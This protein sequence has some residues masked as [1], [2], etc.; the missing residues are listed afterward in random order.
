MVF[1]LAGV[2]DRP[3]RA[4]QIFILIYDQQTSLVKAELSFVVIELA[5]V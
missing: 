2:R 3:G 1:L 4:T 5:M